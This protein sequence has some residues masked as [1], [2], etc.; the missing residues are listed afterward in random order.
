MPTGKLTRWLS[1]IQL[2]DE[3]GD[4]SNGVYHRI[5]M[6]AGPRREIGLRGLDD[7]VVV[8]GHLA[9]GVHRPVVSLAT[10]GQCV[11]PDLAVAVVGIDVLAPI[12]ARGNVIEAA[13]EFESARS[14][15]A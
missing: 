8:I 5:C 12:A 7:E 3:N 4:G 14:G 9:P 10:L 6:V 15:H 2:S 13:T 11:Q 1:A